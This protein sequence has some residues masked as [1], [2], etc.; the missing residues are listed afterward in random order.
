MTDPMD[1]DTAIALRREHVFPPAR[2]SAFEDPAD[3]KSSH[4]SQR[5][6]ALIG[7]YG[8]REPSWYDGITREFAGLDRVLDLGCGPGLSL[9][10]LKAHGV[11]EPIGIDRWQGFRVDAEAAGRRV[12]LHDLT[13]PM[14]FFRSTSFEGLFSHFA[15]DY[16]SPIGVQQVLLEARR[17]LA[18]GGL[19]VL[20][21]AG[22]GLALGDPARTTPYAEPAIT[23]LLS[24][25][26]F[27]DFEIE[28]PRD[29]RNTV[30]RARGPEADPTAQEL[31]GDGTVIEY[32]A[33]GEIQVAAGIRSVRS[34]EGEP[35][36]GIEVSD[37][38]R[39]VG[40]WPQ[41]P[42]AP[43]A[44]EGDAVEGMAVCARLVAVEPGEYE[45]QGWTWQGSQPVAIDT[46]RVQ[47][48]PEVI[49]VRLEPEEGALEHQG[50]WRPQPPMLEPPGDAYTTIER[51]SPNRQPDEE[52]RARG[53][54]VIVE[55]DGDDTDLLQSAA[56]SKDRFLVRRADVAAQPDVAAL[57]RD[58]SEERLHGIA[59]D[60]EAALRPESLPSLLW[61][62]FRGA[63][64]YLEPG[65]WGDVE[66]AAGELLV[67]LR[68]PVL[69][70]D[71]ALSGRAE[72][73]AE[74]EIPLEAIAATLDASPALHLVLAPSTAEG[75]AELTA[76]FPT[77]VLLGD[78][79]EID[80]EARLD[81]QATE[82][83]RYVTERATLM[84]LRST[85]GKTG[86]E[87][88]R[89]TRLAGV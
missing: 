24:A 81:D 38:E 25:A 51:A 73:E 76:R 28:H 29:R 2:V 54:Q 44:A 47:M 66:A 23:R 64:V 61:A 35:V 88:G 57:E 71:P 78:L 58:W 12:I 89:A 56:E 68:S 1:P 14:P 79:D 74:V 20:Y 72:A 48:S 7:F 11:R 3:E 33:G 16:M 80:A 40:Y 32:E 13:L 50:A 37:G 45:L 53:R 36:V 27:E 9:D 43:P 46:L 22:V 49:R 42:P 67:G 77:R 5:Y 8:D 41:L 70:V 85:S 18:P 15:L 59:L 62:G 84:W 87:L 26:G 60:L 34:A 19:M 83:L 30:V 75:A 82:T 52:W 4:G 6:S 63:L 39:S 17:L 86:R 21:M 55:R 69:V 65:S 31:A 10:A